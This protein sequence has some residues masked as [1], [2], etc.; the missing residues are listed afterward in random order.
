MVLAE[1][2]QRKFSVTQGSL[3]PQDPVCI[4]SCYSEVK[5]A[6][7]HNRNPKWKI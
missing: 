6:C 2:S 1:G 5:R 7:E 3:F 4:Q